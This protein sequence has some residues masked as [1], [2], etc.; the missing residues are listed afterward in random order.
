MGCFTNV[1][2]L[3]SQTLTGRIKPRP[4]PSHGFTFICDCTALSG[5]DLVLGLVFYHHLDP[6]CNRPY[7]PLPP[8]PSTIPKKRPAPT[9][10]QTKAI[11]QLTKVSVM[12]IFKSM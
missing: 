5:L 3:Q 10:S 12:L 4:N 7:P 1:P 6:P 8:M 2:P 11:K 9:R